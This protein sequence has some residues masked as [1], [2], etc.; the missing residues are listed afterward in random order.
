MTG[1]EYQTQDCVYAANILPARTV[2]ALETLMK[3]TWV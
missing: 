2:R 3:V 1:T